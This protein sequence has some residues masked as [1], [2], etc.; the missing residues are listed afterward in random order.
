M[1]NLNGKEGKIISINVS[2]KR[3]V[4][5]KP[6]EKVKVLANFGF[7][8]DAHAGNWHRQLSLLAIESIEKMRSK[9]LKVKPGDF[10][11]N[12]TTQNIDLTSLNVGTILRI[13]K[14]VLIEITQI[15]KVC[16]T[17]CA[18]YRQTGECIMPKEGVFAKVLKG[19]EIKMGDIIKITEEKNA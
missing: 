11:E 14:N 5:K 18:I 9:G 13:G 2:R 15:G 3:S 17:K 12:I 10:G 8:G 1:E 16:H 6:V 19:G 7:E 4:R